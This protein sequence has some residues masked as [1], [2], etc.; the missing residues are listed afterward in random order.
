MFE[1]IFLHFFL[2]N[3]TSIVLY[4]SSIIVKSAERK[5]WVHFNICLFIAS[6]IVITT[7]NN[8]IFSSYRAAL[9]IN[10][11]QYMFTPIAYS[12]IYLF[13]YSFKYF[14]GLL[15]L[16]DRDRKGW[17]GGERRDD[18]QQRTA[19]TRLQPLYM[20]CPRYPLQYTST[21]T[22][23]FFTYVFTLKLHYVT[24]NFIDN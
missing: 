4:F 21:P 1:I 12:D 23:I 11:L 16:Y 7:F 18:M 17:K 2:F 19:V 24:F 14:L 20:G 8:R 3:S 5:N 15:C 13:T 22:V 10:I 6:N 9:I